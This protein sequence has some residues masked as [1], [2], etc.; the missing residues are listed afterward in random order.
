MKRMQGA[1]GG[2]RS[3]W[4]APSLTA[5]AVGYIATTASA[6]SHDD[7]TLHGQPVRRLRLPRPLQAVRSRPPRR[8]DQGSD[9]GLRGRTTPSSRSISPPAPARP[10]SRRSR[11]ASSRSS[12][13]SRR[14]SSTCASTAPTRRR[15]STCR[16]STSRRSA[17]VARSSASAPTSAASPIC[18]RK[19]LFAKAGLPDEPRRGVEALADVAGVHQRRQALPGEGPEGHVLLRLGLERLQRD[20]RPAQPGV[21]QRAGNLIVA[22][23]PVG[24]GRLQPDH[25]GLAGR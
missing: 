25:L 22:V 5:V 11:S 24:Q 16:G 2:G 12:P 20:D 13:R 3:R 15:T 19:D 17:R 18:Y 9:P 8:H 6:K 4:S 1:G 21:L 23:E 7:V 14:T 10:T